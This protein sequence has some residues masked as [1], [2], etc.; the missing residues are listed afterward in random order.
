MRRLHDLF[1]ARLHRALAPRGHAG[2]QTWQQDFRCA[3]EPSSGART[4][5]EPWS[6]RRN[7][8]MQRNADWAPVTRGDVSPNGALAR[9]RPPSV[10]GGSFTTFAATF[11]ALP[12]YA[13][14]VPWG[15]ARKATL[16]PPR[17]TTPSGT[18]RVLRA[19]APPT[20]E[21]VALINRAT[22]RSQRFGL[23][24]VT[25]QYDGRL[26]DRWY[27]SPG[28]LADYHAGLHPPR[29]SDGLRHLLNPY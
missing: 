2:P 19:A 15:S 18:P 12:G 26:R 6:Q 16:S 20:P 3:D 28:E 17:Q 13:S 22:S 24:P 27:R 9:S 1:Q 4:K 11:A 10:A 8:F 5:M 21:A 25:V 23:R 14:P 29:E 7:H